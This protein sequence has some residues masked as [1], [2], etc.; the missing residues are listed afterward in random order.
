MFPSFIVGLS[1]NFHGS[2]QNRGRTSAFK[3]L[4]VSE[5]LNFSSKSARSFINDHTGTNRNGQELLKKVRPSYN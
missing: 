1:E 5:R 2:N 3:I 4:Q